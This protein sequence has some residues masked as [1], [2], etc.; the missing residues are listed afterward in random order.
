MWVFLWMHNVIFFIRI[1]SLI[2][3]V[4]KICLDHTEMTLTAYK[5]KAALAVFSWSKER[6]TFYLIEHGL[7]LYKAMLINYYLCT[8]SQL[9]IILCIACHL[10]KFKNCAAS[11]YQAPLHNLKPPPKKGV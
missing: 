10:S 8:S 7:S 1:Y 5:I 6:F 4:S 9:D 2:K 11:T 3:Y